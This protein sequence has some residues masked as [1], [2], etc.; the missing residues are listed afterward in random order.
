MML[1]AAVLMMLGAAVLLVAARRHQ[2]VVVATPRQV[3]QST[4]TNLQD[5]MAGLGLPRALW[6]DAAILFGLILTCVMI[7]RSQ[8]YLPA[9]G[10]MVVA[11]LVIVVIAQ[12][13]RE[14]QRR[15]ILEQLP[16]FISQLARRVRT[17]TSVTKAFERAVEEAKVPLQD[18]MRQALH[19]VQLGDDLPN[20]MELKARI[21][22]VDEFYLLASILRVHYQ[23]GGSI[24]S[25]LEHLVKLLHQ[26]ERAHRELWALTGE[27]RVTAIILGV[28]PVLMAL[29][30]LVANSKYI[31]SLWNDSTGQVVLLSAIGLQVI[32]SFIL[33]RMLRS[34]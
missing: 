33:W 29:Y 8:G 4:I 18:V 27:T 17:G 25:A 1:L 24:S 26:R 7:W 34:V 2:P 22:G 28:V 5:W 19:R 9:I 11:V 14:R 30:M 12:I 20:C 3:R 16:G 10:V 32:G 31:L 6:L 13:R 23:F 21:T 15:Q